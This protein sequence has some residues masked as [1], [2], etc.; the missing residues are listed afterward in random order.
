MS[1]PKHYVPLEVKKAYRE[2]REYDSVRHRNLREEL[3]TADAAINDGRC[4]RCACRLLFVDPTKN[5]GETDEQCEY[6]PF[7]IVHA[8]AVAVD[9]RPTFN[10]RPT[11]KS[12][13]SRP[14]ST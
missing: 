10:R 8:P 6:C 3:K 12:Y 5:H 4:P 9:P 7:R 14:V 2:V 13:A 1:R 11:K